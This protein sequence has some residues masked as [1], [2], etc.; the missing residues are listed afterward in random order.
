MDNLLTKENKHIEVSEVDYM[1]K[2]RMDQLFNCF[3]EIATVNAI[4]LGL[5]SQDMMQ[6]YGWVVAK[7]SLH[8]DEPIQCGDHIEISTLPGKPTFVSFPRYYFIQKEGR[9]IGYCSSI[10]T[11]IDLRRRRIVSLK[12]EGIQIP[13]IDHDVVLAEPKS[14]EMNI[15]M[16]YVTTRKV[17]YSDVDTNQHMNNTR[18][19]QWALDIIDYSIHQ[20]YDMCDITVQYKKEI[21]PLTEVQLYLGKDG[22]RYIVE[23]KD[24]DNEFFALEILFTQRKR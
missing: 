8:L 15:P 17:C 7:Q 3:A 5:W 2:Y 4:K 23:G 14:I 20:D 22:L 24:Q 10:W 19:I 18:Y 16:T 1:G 9:T 21:P 12:R 11:L 6:S 13:K